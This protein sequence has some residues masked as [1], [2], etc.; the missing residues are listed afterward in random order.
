MKFYYSIILII[1]MFMQCSTY[2]IDQGSQVRQ[3]TFDSQ[4]HSLDNNDNFS[5]DDEWLVY[6]TR[7]EGIGENPVIGKVNVKTGEQVIVYKTTNQ[8]EFGPGVGAAFYAHNQN[9]VAFIHGL[10][11]CNSK[12]PYAKWRRFGMIIDEDNGNKQLIADARDVIFP[13]TPGA[14][15][16]GTHRHEWSAD[17]QWLAFTYDDAI[18]EQLEKVT[19]EK[20][21][22]RTMGVT[23]LGMPVKVDK[24]QDGENHDGQGFS[25]LIVKIIPEPKPLSDEISSAF[26]DSWIGQ[27]GYQKKDG[28]LQRARVFLGKTRNEKNEVITEA[29]V[30]D[31]P[32]KIDIAGNDGPLEGEKMTMPSPPRGTVQRRLTNTVCKKYPGIEFVRSSPDGNTISFFAKDSVGNTQVFLIPTQGGEVKQVTFLPNLINSGANLRWNP[33]GKEICFVA[34]NFVY[35]C[36]IEPGKNFGKIHPLTKKY[37]TS[38]HSLV[39]SHDGKTIAFNRI[40]EDNK[41]KYKQ[42]YIIEF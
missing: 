15:R 12:N 18:M 37:Q 30:V 42:I 17:G 38:P 14:L 19:G 40:V 35:K 1:L 27:N 16:G 5:P 31:I 13:F 23:K 29:F 2:K 25:V 8:T 21:N 4:N 32:E 20:V 22:L 9:K 34:D 36:N 6:D 11:N 41:G 7:S 28:T 33:N 3:L 24:D 10:Q 39:W 26:S